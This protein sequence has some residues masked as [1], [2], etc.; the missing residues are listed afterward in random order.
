[1]YAKVFKSMYDGSMYGAGPVIFATWIWILTHCDQDGF[2]EINPK[3]LAPMIGTDEDQIIMALD[4]LKAPDSDSRTPVLEGRRIEKIGPYLH[5]V[6]NYEKYRKL[7]SLEDRRVQNREAKR[8]ERAKNCD[9][10]HDVSI[11]QQPS[12]MSAQVEVEVDTEVEVKKKK[13]YV[14]TSDEVRLSELLFSLIQNRKPD[15]KKPNLQTWALHVDRMIRLDGRSPDR[16][17]AAIE[18][19]QSDDFWQDNILSTEKL[20]KQFDKLELKLSKV[21][22]VAVKQFPKCGNCGERRDPWTVYC[23]V[24]YCSTECKIKK[25]GY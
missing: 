11:C 21:K 15:Y 22:G 23:G 14:G 17:E 10:Q 6:V 4:Y 2:V 5:Q 12:A 16:I 20:R 25:V 3:M 7:A 13:H 24:P 1:M 19:A 8:R 9:C 18:F